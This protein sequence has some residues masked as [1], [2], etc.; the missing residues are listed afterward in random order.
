VLTGVLKTAQCWF[1]HQRFLGSGVSD[2]DS[3]NE[4]QSSRE[5]FFSDVVVTLG[6]DGVSATLCCVVKA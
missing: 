6:R 5:A 4:M 3:R 1:V 2:L